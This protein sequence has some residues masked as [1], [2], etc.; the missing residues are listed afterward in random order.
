[1]APPAHVVG[2]RLV[3]HE[4]ALDVDADHTREVARRLRASADRK[5]QRGE[6]RNAARG[7]YAA[8]V[9]A[10]HCPFPAAGV[11]FTPATM[12]FLDPPLSM[13]RTRILLPAG[14]V[15]SCFSMGAGPSNRSVGSLGINA[16]ITWRPRNG[17]PLKSRNDV[18]PIQRSG[19]LS[20]PM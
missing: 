14:A 6:Q 2:R 17:S 4:R 16:R 12:K 10:G 7:P 9:H 3:L 5:Q 18:T 11:T 19:V 13:P 8:R 15:F 1:D 20:S